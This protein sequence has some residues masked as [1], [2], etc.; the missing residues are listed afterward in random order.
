MTLVTEQRK[1]AATLFADMA[2]YR[3]QRLKVRQLQTASR[4]ANR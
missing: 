1:P 4:P 2:G 3:C